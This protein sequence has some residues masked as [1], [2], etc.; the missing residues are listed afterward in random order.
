MDGDKKQ[1][2]ILGGHTGT[3]SIAIQIAKY[4]GCQVTATVSAGAEDWA[5]R[6]GADAVVA[7]GSWWEEFGGQGFDAVFDTLGEDEA[8]ERA[9]LVLK[10][11]VI[12]FVCC[13]FHLTR[14][15]A[16]KGAF[17]TELPEYLRKSAGV[18]AWV[19]QARSLS[20]SL[21]FAECR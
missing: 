12:W 4:F 20:L 14:V 11:K 13:F 6:L 15:R 17:A 18:G 9:K 16:V 3:G 7:H 8:F 2:L 1:V 19:K 5:R 10:D 21:L